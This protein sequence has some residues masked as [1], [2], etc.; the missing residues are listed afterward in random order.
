MHAGAS[1]EKDDGLERRR[2][3]YRTCQRI[4]L[5]QMA[6]KRRRCQNVLFA[7]RLN[8]TACSGQPSLHLLRA[9]HTE[10]A[11]VDNVGQRHAAALSFDDFGNR[12]EGPDESR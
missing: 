8:I 12:I 3:I 9:L 5:R 10:R 7:F 6:K 11:R 4:E 1:D 2:K